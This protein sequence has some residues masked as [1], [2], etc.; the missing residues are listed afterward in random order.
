MAQIKPFRGVR[1]NDAT[2]RDLSPVLAPPHDTVSPIDYNALCRKYARNSVQ[3]TVSE[4]EPRSGRR[5]YARSADALE[6][7]LADE[8]LIQDHAPALYL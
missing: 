7:W 6:E 8:T 3:L 5:A 2:Y 1:Y 4:P